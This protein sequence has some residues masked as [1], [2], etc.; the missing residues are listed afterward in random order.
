MCGA[1]PE[2][3]PADEFDVLYSSGTTGVPKGIVHDH[4]IRKASYLGSRAKYFSTA[5]VNVLSTRLKTMPAPE[6]QALY[7][8]LV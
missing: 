8:A 3:G 1:F 7:T 6:T 5:S 4:A 2:I